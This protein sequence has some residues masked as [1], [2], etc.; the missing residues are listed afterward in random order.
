[1]PA[2]SAQRL[3]RLRPFQIAAL[4]GLIAGVLYLLLLTQQYSGD[5]MRWYASI[6][7]A[8]PLTLGGTNHLLFPVIDRFYFQTLTALGVPAAFNLAQSINAIFGGLG[9]ACFAYLLFIWTRR[10]SISI[11]GAAILAFSRAYSINAT[12]M[13]EPMIGTALVLFAIVLISLFVTRQHRRWLISAAAIGIAIG[14]AIYQGNAL[15]LIGACAILWLCDPNTSRRSRLINVGLCAAVAGAATLAIF[16]GAF[17]IFGGATSIAQALALSLRTESDATLGIYTEFSL[18]RIGV[19]IFGLGDALFGLRGIDGEG[20]NFFSH[21]LTPQVIWSVLLVGWSVMV[22]A[23]I[24]A[25]YIFRRLK[26]SGLNQRLVW[27]G[28]VW[29]LP[30]GSSSSFGARAKASCGSC[31]W[32]VSF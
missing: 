30:G 12:D 23:T 1:M 22:V 15:S 20:T 24:A 14:A 4:A 6:S 13:T 19:S 21:G 8:A 9:I 27:A 16:I 10:W 7:G 17:L 2:S 28:L 32:R 26:L 31:R 11:G 5:G 18:R 29:F 3:S 25:P